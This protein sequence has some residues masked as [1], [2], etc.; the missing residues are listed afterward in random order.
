[1]LLLFLARASVHGEPIR[2]SHC[3]IEE[4]T[5]LRSELEAHVADDDVAMGQENSAPAF[6]SGMRERIYDPIE[7]HHERKIRRWLEAHAKLAML[8]AASA[9]FDV[10]V[11]RFALRSGS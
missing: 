4:R 6:V 3:F 5:Q 2:L 10:A 7:L 1:L 11:H 8:H 9:P